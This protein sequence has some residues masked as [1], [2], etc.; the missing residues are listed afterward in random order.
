MREITQQKK[1]SMVFIRNLLESQKANA[2]F[3]TPVI[4]DEQ[5]IIKKLKKAWKK[6]PLL[7]KANQVNM[8]KTKSPGSSA[9]SLIF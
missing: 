1:L 8:R 6:Q 3:I 2:L 9:N 4:T 7:H 5:G